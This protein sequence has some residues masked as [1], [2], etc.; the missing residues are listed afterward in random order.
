MNKRKVAIIAGLILLI[1]ILGIV[2]SGS[3]TVRIDDS[4]KNQPVLKSTAAESKRDLVVKLGNKLSFKCQV[5]FSHTDQEMQISNILVTDV[6]KEIGAKVVVNISS[7]L[8]PDKGG[9]QAERLNMNLTS[10]NL[11]GSEVGSCVMKI[12][13]NGAVV[14][15]SKTENVE[16]NY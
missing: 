16:V 6:D 8:V 1:A 14:P 12:T 10:S 2:S 5:W 3:T 15:D 13:A 4:Y 11:F 9:M 7:M